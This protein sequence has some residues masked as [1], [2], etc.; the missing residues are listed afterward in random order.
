MQLLSEFR[1]PTQWYSK[2]VAALLAIIFFILMAAAII[3]GY[4]VYSIVTVNGIAHDDAVN[5]ASFPGHPE[6]VSFDVEGVGERDGWF[7]PGLKLAPT[8]VL[9]PGY[10]AS[11]GELLPLAT[12]LQDHQYNVLLFDFDTHG[13]SAGNSTLGFREVR[14]LRAAVATIAQRSDVD[15]SRFG[16]WGTNMGGYVA[17]AVAETDPRVRAMVAESVYDQPQDMVRLLVARDGLDHLPLLSRFAVKVFTTL[18][19]QSRGTPPLSARLSRLAGTAK[20]FVEANDSPGL[21][22]STHRLSVL[23][24]EP[25][26]EVLLSHGNYAGML[27]DEKRAYENRIVTFFLTNL[28]PEPR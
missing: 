8:I 4:V 18:N 10:H 13:S 6:D 2:L 26:Q 9:C 17:V 24:P 21:V 5:L 7:F 23:S 12:A 25:K 3:A 15:G 27:D 22:E 11:R 28:P 1:N 20:L 19:Y 16:F 14:E